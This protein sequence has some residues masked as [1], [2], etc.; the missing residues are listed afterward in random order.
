MRSV[1]QQEP[2]EGV[3]VLPVIVVHLHPTVL[4][5]ISMLPRRQVC[6]VHYSF[7]S[8]C[9]EASKLLK[10]IVTPPTVKPLSGILD[11]YV[12]LKE[13]D[14]QR[15]QLIQAN[16]IVG[17]LLAVLDNHASK[18]STQHKQ[19]DTQHE[20]TSA[21]QPVSE[22]QLPANDQPVEVDMPASE[23]SFNEMDGMATDQ[24]VTDDATPAPQQADQQVA[25][26]LATSLPRPQSS[27]QHRKGAPRRRADQSDGV[28]SP[29]SRLAFSSLGR[30][31]PQTVAASIF[32]PWTH[33]LVG[34]RE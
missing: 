30:H 7:D 21:E 1:E 9:R 3:R 12:K 20:P 34:S 27:S 14:S 8:C 17:D 32:P 11:E 31:S 19:A 33:R 10:S 25:A 13:A 2:S 23:P 15:K 28:A 24:H 22:P 18:P 6:R 4:V 16:P 26:R 29:I 5:H